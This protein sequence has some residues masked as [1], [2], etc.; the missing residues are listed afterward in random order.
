MKY[1]DYIQ[2]SERDYKLM[3]QNYDELIN[4]ETADLEE[5]LNKMQNQWN[6]LKADNVDGKYDEIL[7]KLQGNI[8]E[9]S[10]II[11]NNKSNIFG[12]NITPNIP[13]P[14]RPKL[15]KLDTDTA[16]SPTR[17]WDEMRAHSPSQTL[18][19][20]DTNLDDIIGTPSDIIG[21]I[22]SPSPAL[23][24]D[25]NSPS[26]SPTPSP[27][28]PSLPNMNDGTNQAPNT[29]SNETS[30][31]T[32]DNLTS[33]DADNSSTITPSEPTPTTP[34][35][36]DN[37]NTLKRNSPMQSN[38]LF[39]TFK[40]FNVNLNRIFSHSYKS[41]KKG[42]TRDTQNSTNY[43][44]QKSTIYSQ[45]RYHHSYRPEG[46]L[47]PVI[48]YDN[49]VDIIRLMLLYLMLRPNCK[50]MS[51]I[52]KLTNEQFDILLGLKAI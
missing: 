7:D 15:K 41:Q 10:G 49:Q 11:E 30:N 16:I 35:Q 24:N 1:N 29:P 25:T 27:I 42:A 18:P 12:N 23:P 37:T 6:N 26:T 38:A 36:N 19:S 51:R 17:S 2:P 52:A 8:D 46:C 39:T 34:I 32:G 45:N 43:D 13:I 20:R 21:D 33:E 9:L 28:T 44:K 31:N 47:P 5:I 4:N 22:L 50:Y 48:F 14:L 3:K 40:R